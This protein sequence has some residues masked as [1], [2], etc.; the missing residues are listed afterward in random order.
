MAKLIWLQFDASQTWWRLNCWFYREMLYKDGVLKILQAVKK[1]QTQVQY[2]EGSFTLVNRETSVEV[3]LEKYFNDK[4]GRINWKKFFPSF[5]FSKAFEKNMKNFDWGSF[6]GFVIK[7]WN[8]ETSNLFCYS[9]RVATLA[10]S[11]SKTFLL[12]ELL[13]RKRFIHF[14][15][16]NEQNEWRMNERGDI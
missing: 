7:F 2:A 12:S 10:L 11:P 16:G 6:L 5:F 15:M 8:E 14:L 4:K 13:I 9:S 1:Q 3:F